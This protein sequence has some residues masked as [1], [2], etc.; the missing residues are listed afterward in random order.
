MTKV[1]IKSA[2]ECMKLIQDSP[3][4]YCVS[5]RMV[6]IFADTIA[7]HYGYVNGGEGRY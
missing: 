5:T 6:D 1:R 2:E 4:E 3:Y 7:E